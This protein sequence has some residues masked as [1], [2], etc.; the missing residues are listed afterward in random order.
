MRSHNPH[1]VVR[2]RL[3]A[4]VETVTR[5]SV[6]L[7]VLDPAG[8]VLLLHAVLPEE[9][10]WEPP[11]GGIDEGERAVDAAIRE[12]REETGIDLGDQ[13]L[14]TLGAV[15]TE[16]VWRQRRYLQNEEVFVAHVETR[17]EVELTP[18][19]PPS[20]R[21]IAFAWWSPTDLADSTV[22]VH[23]PQLAELLR[24]LSDR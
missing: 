20:A 14:M 23:P 17:P 21:H 18:D 12:L 6:R 13:E 24:G 5:N 1:V 7:A 19:E 9:E 3:S 10:W 11:G 4:D 2:G 8:A 16:F 22:A 15:E